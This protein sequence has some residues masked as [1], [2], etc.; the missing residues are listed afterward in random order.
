MMRALKTKRTVGLIDMEPAQVETLTNIGYTIGYIVAGVLT[1]TA[2]YRL[3]PKKTLEGSHDHSSWSSLDERIERIAES[4]EGIGI[5][6]KRLADQIVSSADM[7]KQASDARIARLL[8]H[9]EEQEA[10]PH[11]SPRRRRKV[12]KKAQ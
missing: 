7:S 1:A 3:T 6:V 5:H 11:R 12:V 4:L 8:A 10:K 2:A 9:I